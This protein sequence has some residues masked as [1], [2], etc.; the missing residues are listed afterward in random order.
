M[1]LGGVISDHVV[2]VL[3]AAAWWR[4]LLIPNPQNMLKAK[5]LFDCTADDEAE[6]TFTEGDIIVD[7]MLTHPRS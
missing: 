7:G 2:R 1:R 4:S 5:A 3:A 6:L